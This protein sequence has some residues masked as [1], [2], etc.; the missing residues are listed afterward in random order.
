MPRT[1]THD[2]IEAVAQR[3]VALLASSPRPS[4]SAAADPKRF[5]SSAAVMALLGYRNRSSFWQFAHSNH[6]PCVRLGPKR[7]VFDRLQLE[8][9]FERRSTVPRRRNASGF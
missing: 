4:V 5:L 8:D 3:V 1:L 2:D 6:V 7:I 9:W